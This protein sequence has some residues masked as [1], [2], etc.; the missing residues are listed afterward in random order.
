MRNF[1]HHEFGELKRNTLPDGTRTYKTP[2]GKSYPSVTTVTGLLGKAAI[3]EWR[4]RVGEEEATK[5]STRAATRGTKIHTLCE[6][7]L[8]GKTDNF[9]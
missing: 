4:K 9:N 8:L 1:I 7:Y 5:I 6:N 3:I 2:T